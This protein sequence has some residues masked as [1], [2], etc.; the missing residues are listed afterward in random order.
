MEMRQA[1]FRS[2]RSVKL[3]RLMEIV[4]EAAQD[5]MKVV[6]FSYFRGVLA[7]VGRELGAT[8]I[9]EINGSVPPALRQQI[10][11]DFARRHEHAVLLDQIEAG[12]VGINMQAKTLLFD[13]F[14]RRVTRRTLTVVPSTPLSTARGS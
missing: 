7:T 11:D 10:L 4:E 5:S 6:V 3:E 2:P 14:A 8:V 1:V 9:G 12:G 13:E